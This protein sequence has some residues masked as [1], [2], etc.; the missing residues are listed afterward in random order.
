MS[1]FTRFATVALIAIGLLPVRAVCQDVVT[2]G[3]K[4]FTG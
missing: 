2:V 1:R 4:K 3:S